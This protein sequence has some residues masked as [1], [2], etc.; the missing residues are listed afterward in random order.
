MIHTSLFSKFGPRVEIMESSL[1]FGKMW[2]LSIFHSIE[3]SFPGNFL[4][5]TERNKQFVIRESTKVTKK[6]K[7]EST[8]NHS[9]QLTCQ[10]CLIMGHVPVLQDYIV[11][12]MSQY[13]V[14][15]MSQNAW[16]WVTSLC[17]KITSLFWCHKT[18]IAK[19]LRWDSNG[20]YVCQVLLVLNL[21]MLQKIRK[22]KDA[23][24]KQGH[25]LKI[26][27]VIFSKK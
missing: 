23:S 5:K 8:I 2:N 26:R 14:F 4:K 20:L 13:I 27:T 1:V 3:H 17:C 18:L 10:Q 24:H 16:Y 9:R 21:V 25:F 19:C 6:Q 22:N 12:L 15:F 7:R 11:F